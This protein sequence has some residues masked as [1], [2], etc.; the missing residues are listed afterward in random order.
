MATADDLIAV[1]TES[2]LG[3]V[4]DDIRRFAEAARADLRSYRAS[5]VGLREDAPAQGPLE[6]ATLFFIPERYQEQSEEFLVFECF[7]RTFVDP[8]ALGLAVLNHL[9]STDAD[10]LT[11]VIFDRPGALDNADR[12]S[13]DDVPRLTSALQELQELAYMIGAEVFG[14]AFRRSDFWRSRGNN[15]QG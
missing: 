3:F 9:R 12:L 14:G 5:R 15:R 7:V 10:E 6:P 1:L 4:P 13:I 8:V 11:G 2:G